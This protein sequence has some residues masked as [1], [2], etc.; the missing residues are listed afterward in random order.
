MQSYR[1][2]EKQ[3][4][5]VFLKINCLLFTK[6]PM[7]KI[8]NFPK[9]LQKRIKKKK[10]RFWFYHRTLNKSSNLCVSALTSLKIPELCDKKRNEILDLKQLEFKLQARG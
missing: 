4:E 10:S 5:R 3:N 8:V 1:I 2:Y 9:E 7:K 6:H